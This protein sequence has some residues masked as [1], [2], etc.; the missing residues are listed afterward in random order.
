MLQINIFDTEKG[1][2]VL[3][4]TWDR[5]NFL[6]YDSSLIF[7]SYEEYIKSVPTFHKKIIQAAKR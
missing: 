6:D 1:P 4:W 5:I 2:N 7:P 3:N